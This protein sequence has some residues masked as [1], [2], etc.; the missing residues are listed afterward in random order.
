M[1]KSKEITKSSEFVYCAK[2]YKYNVT[3]IMYN[4]RTHESGGYIC[5]Q[6]HTNDYKEALDYADGNAD[7]FQ[8]EEDRVLGFCEVVELHHAK[9]LMDVEGYDEYSL[10]DEEWNRLIRMIYDDF[11]SDDPL[12]DMCEE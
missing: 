8:N 12:V 3:C 6:L 2:G 11:A 9:M 5:G 1:M 4:G 10:C 7:F